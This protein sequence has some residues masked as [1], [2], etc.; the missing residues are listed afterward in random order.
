MFHYIGSGTAVSQWVLLG[1]LGDR[2]FWFIITGVDRILK[3]E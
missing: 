2:R 1:L 3:Y